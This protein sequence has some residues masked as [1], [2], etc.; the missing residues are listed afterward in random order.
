MKFPLSTFKTLLIHEFLQKHQ[1]VSI[2]SP[3]QTAKIQIPSLH[4]KGGEA[5]TYFDFVTK[6]HE[7]ALITFVS[8]IKSS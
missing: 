8:P 3:P 5:K 7:K 2:K 4:F 1:Q 6:K